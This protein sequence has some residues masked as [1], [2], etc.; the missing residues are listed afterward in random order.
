MQDAS[1]EKKD[2]K[3]AE[4]FRDKV[5]VVVFVFIILPGD[6]LEQRGKLI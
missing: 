6:I 2:D 4:I 3:G 1:L 5:D